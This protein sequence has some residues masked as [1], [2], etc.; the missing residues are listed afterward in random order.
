MRRAPA[1]STAGLRRVLVIA[2]LVTGLAC[3]AE[4]PYTWVQDLPQ[5][6][7]AG[8]NGVVRPRDTIAV[9]VRDQP[10]M[11]GE[12]VVR[13]DGGYIQPTLGN[14]AVAD[15]MPAAIAA[16]IQSRLENVIVRPQVSVS[17]ARTAS[18]RVSVVG[19]V[20]TPGTYELTRDKTVM[21]SLAAAG[22]LTDFASKDRIFVVRS[23]DKGMRVR[24]RAQ[25]LTAPEPASAQ[26]Q[27]RDGD[28]VV[29]E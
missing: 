2:T 3:A 12:F 4:R 25:A 29:V 17:I 11:S 13:E 19:E 8:P 23:A 5:L 27:V 22:W 18:V 7:P 28:V 24:F 6:P 16:E 21:A 14:V 1:S 10:A 9:L 26:F 15:R 20:K